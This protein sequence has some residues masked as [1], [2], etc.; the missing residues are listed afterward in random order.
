MRTARLLHVVLGMGM[1]FEQ[2]TTTQRTED[3][4]GVRRNALTFALE[5]CHSAL[6]HDLKRTDGDGDALRRAIPDLMQLARTEG[7]PPER[8]LSAFKR[9][10]DGVL[11]ATTLG[12]LERGEIMRRATQVA[13]ESY[14]VPL[15]SAGA[16]A[17]RS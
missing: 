9:M 17:A 6:C 2:G 8:V 14:F 7:V 5:Q 1:V 16:R 3:T 12:A 4:L 10:M 15:V 13:I 11:R